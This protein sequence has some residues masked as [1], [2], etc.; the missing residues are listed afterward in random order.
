MS[1]EERKKKLYQ[2]DIWCGDKA[3]ALGYFLFHIK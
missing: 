3:I 2:G 1:L